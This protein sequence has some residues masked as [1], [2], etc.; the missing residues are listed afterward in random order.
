MPSFHRSRVQ[1]CRAWQG[2]NRCRGR[3]YAFGSS[4]IYY[5]VG[6]A[7]SAHL[8]QVQSGELHVCGNPVSYQDIDQL[9]KEVKGCEHEGNAS[10]RANC[11]GQKLARVPVKEPAN[12][13]RHAIEAFTIDAIGKQAQRKYTPCSVHAVN[14]EDRK[15]TRLNSSHTVT[16]YAV[17]C[18]KK[19]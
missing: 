4:G 19:K 9:E 11:L 16:S 6:I 10:H 18:L 1:C 7:Q 14:G 12:G 17:F 15:S 8:G 2:R 3:S 13:P 5:K